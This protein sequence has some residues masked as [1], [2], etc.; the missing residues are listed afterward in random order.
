[1]RALSG[2]YSEIKEEFDF[3]FD[4]INVVAVQRVDKRREGE[5]DRKRER[6]RARLR[7]K[8]F[9]RELSQIWAAPGRPYLYYNL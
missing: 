4:G 7:E 8:P 2:P 9:R 5:R 3:L 6:E 1:M